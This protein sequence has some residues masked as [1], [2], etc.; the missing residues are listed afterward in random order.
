MARLA[1]TPVDMT[2]FERA[3]YVYTAEEEVAVP[4]ELLFDSLQSAEDWPCWAKPIQKVEWTSP[5]PFGIGTTRTVYMMAGMTGYEEFI[6]WERGREMAFCFTHC[7]KPNVDS[8]AERYEITPLGDKRCR[9]RW[10]MAMKPKGLSNVFMP[11]VS[12]LMR[13]GVKQMLKAL[14]RLLENRAQQNPQHSS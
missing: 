1:C 12:P 4:A 2:F 14:R 5:Q 6:A 3:P 11:M 10:T 8:F 13:L 9:L 7:S